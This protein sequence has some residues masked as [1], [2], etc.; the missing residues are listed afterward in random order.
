MTNQTATAPTAGPGVNLPSLM[1]MDE[2]GSLFV[3]HIT[4]NADGSLTHDLDGINKWVGRSENGHFALVPSWT[5]VG[6]EVGFVTIPAGTTVRCYASADNAIDVET[7]FGV[8]T[9][10]DCP[11]VV[12]H[13]AIDRDAL[14]AWYAG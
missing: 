2:P 7:A 10:T 9:F 12:A 1:L 3:E 13:A 4:A 14:K 6:A 8:I 11:V 5:K